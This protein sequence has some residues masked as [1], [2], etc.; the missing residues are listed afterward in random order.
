MKCTR[1]LSNEPS[2]R[3][4]ESYLLRHQIN[5]PGRYLLR[6]FWNSLR[7]YLWGTCRSL[8]IASSDAGVNLLRSHPQGCHWKS[9]RSERHGGPTRTVDHHV[10]RGEGKNTPI[11]ERSL[12]LLKWPYSALYWQNVTEPAKVKY[13][14]LTSQTG[15]GGSIGHKKQKNYLL[16]KGAICLIWDQASQFTLYLRFAWF[17]FFCTLNYDQPA[18]LYLKCISFR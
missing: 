13:L 17:I 15:Q 9:L 1:K 8:W 10:P 5:C 4:A 14:P 11:W 18:F 7:R 12:Y 6:C 3:L 16:A 2:L